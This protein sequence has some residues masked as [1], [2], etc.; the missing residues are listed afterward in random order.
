MADWDEEADGTSVTV[1]EVPSTWNDEEDDGPA[2]TSWDAEETKQEAKP[3]TNVKSRTKELSKKQMQKEE[4][5]RKQALEEARKRDMDPI[6]KAQYKKEQIELLKEA[7]RGLAEDLFRVDHVCREKEEKKVLE[8]VI[9]K[10]DHDFE[11]FAKDV[12]VKIKFAASLEPKNEVKRLVEFL[13]IVTKEASIKLKSEDINVLKQ[14]I[15]VLFN[16]KVK[17]AAPAKKK[18]SGSKKTLKMSVDNEYAAK[19][20]VSVADAVNDTNTDE[21][22]FM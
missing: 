12:A 20:N 14:S 9:L 21:Y 11:Q 13:K 19:T 10:T 7:D 17:E 1:A 5:E 8:N 22:D 18:K 6:A 16:D 3:S 4:A 2:P 15:T